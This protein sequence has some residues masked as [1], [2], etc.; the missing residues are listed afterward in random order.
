MRKKQYILNLKEEL[1]HE[2]FIQKSAKLPFESLDLPQEYSSTGNDVD[3]NL[4]IIKDKG[5]YIV[6]L[7]INSDIQVECSR[8][9][10][11]FNMDLVGSS[12]VVLSKKRK[13]TQELKEKDLNV[14]YLENEEQ[15]NVNNLVREEIIVQTPMK[16]LCSENCKGIC[17]V[18]GNNKNENPCNCEEK[19]KREMSPFSQ[20]KHLLDKK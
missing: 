12:S 5:D 11:P 3:I 20:L 8:C 4:Y 14:E 9:L 13:N 1:K 16:P 15:F 18:C 2:N 17:Q 6:S 19:Q 7:D 10:E